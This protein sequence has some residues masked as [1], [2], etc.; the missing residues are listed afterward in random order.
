MQLPD[1][2]LSFWALFLSGL[3]IYAVPFTLLSW[4]IFSG[5]AQVL[6]Y[7]VF[8]TVV[9]AV[10]GALWPTPVYRAMCSRLPWNRR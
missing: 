1:H 9:V 5:L 10:V 8:G 2:Q 6:G 3:V 7:A 4:A